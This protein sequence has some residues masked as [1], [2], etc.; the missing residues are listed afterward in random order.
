MIFSV[1]GS[2]VGVY[3]KMPSMAHRFRFSLRTLLIVVALCALVVVLWREYG[4]RSAVEGN[5]RGTGRHHNIQMVF[6]GD[7]LSIA[8][9]VGTQSSRFRVDAAKGLIEIH[10]DDGIQQG[11]F[12]VKDDRLELRLA[13]VGLAVPKQIP[14]SE[15][16]TMYYVFEREP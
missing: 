1:V 5:W 7:Q 2:I 15:R 6:H 4:I 8:N 16:D 11:R 10:R 3:G 14:Q 9:R 13:N 12:Q